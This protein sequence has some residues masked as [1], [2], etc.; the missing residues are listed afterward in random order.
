MHEHNSFHHVS[1]HILVDFSC[2]FLWTLN[3]GSKG[4]CERVGAPDTLSVHLVM[5]LCAGGELLDW[6]Q[7]QVH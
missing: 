6:R 3:H 7:G 4:V 1:I 2:P 5:E